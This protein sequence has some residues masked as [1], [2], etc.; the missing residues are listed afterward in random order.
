MQPNTNS[1]KIPVHFFEFSTIEGTMVVAATHCW[2]C[3]KQ[4]DIE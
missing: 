3:E 4:E 2:K 1:Y